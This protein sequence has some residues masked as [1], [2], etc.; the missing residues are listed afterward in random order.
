M[1]RLKLNSVSVFAG[2]DQ[3]TL[4]EEPQVRLDGLFALA[5]KYL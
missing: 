3:G 5:F 2:E 1:R 4:L